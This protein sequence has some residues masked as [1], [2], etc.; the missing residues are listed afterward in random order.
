MIYETDTDQVRVW[1]GTTWRLILPQLTQQN[2]R[3]TIDT[4]FSTTPADIIGATLNVTTITANTPVQVAASFDLEHTLAGGIEAIG[5]LVVDGV[6][7]LGQALLDQSCIRAT[8]SQ[9]WLVTVATP[10]VHVFKLQGSKLNAAGTVQAHAFH[11]A[12][13]V[14][15]GSW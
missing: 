11:T 4:V 13:N 8:S 15:F 6:T 5:E 7:Q 10:G 1:T 14:I 12:L 3:A 2:A 9:V